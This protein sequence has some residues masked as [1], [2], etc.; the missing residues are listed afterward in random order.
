V[1]DP[2]QIMHS[3]SAVKRGSNYGGFKNPEVDKLIE[4][5]RQEFDSEKRKQLYWRLQE[6]IHEEQPY[7]FVLWLQE[8]GAYTKR[9]QGVTFVPA[10][11]GYDLNAWFVPRAAQKYTNVSTN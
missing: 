9:F 7:T 4:Q 8:A 11:P 2:Y 6:I 1:N 10:R 3:S 5:A